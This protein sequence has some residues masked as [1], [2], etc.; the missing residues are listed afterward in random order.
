MDRNLVFLPSENFE[1]VSQELPTWGMI[2]TRS[3]EIREHDDI[4]FGGEHFECTLKQE[5]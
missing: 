4:A 2:G 3:L 5:F 1:R